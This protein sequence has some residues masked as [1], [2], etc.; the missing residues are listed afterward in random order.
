MKKVGL[1]VRFETVNTIRM[2]EIDFYVHTTRED[3]IVCKGI[4]KLAEEQFSC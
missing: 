3:V 4:N 2:M 1:V